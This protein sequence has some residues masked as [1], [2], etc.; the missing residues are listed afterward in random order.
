MAILPS[1][2]ES[3]PFASPLAVFSFSSIFESTSVSM[4]LTKKLATLALWLTS[5]PF[6]NARFQRRQK[7]FG[8]LLI[9][10]L[11][12]QKS[13]VDVEPVFQQLANCRDTGWRCRA[14]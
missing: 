9:R 10:G 14:P 12:K 1:I 13:H 4:R 6:E 7:R 2:L 11:R 8:Y 5:K 3:R